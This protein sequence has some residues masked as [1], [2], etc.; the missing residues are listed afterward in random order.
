M[1]GH[2]GLYE[3]DMS[4]GAKNWRAYL[5]HHMYSR[6]II[7]DGVWRF[8]I[9]TLGAC[10]A[11]MP[12]R[13]VDFVVRRVDGTD[14]RMHPGSEKDTVPIFG[15]LTDWLQDERAAPLPPA[16]AVSRG[17]IHRD[18]VG[19]HCLASGDIISRTHIKQWLNERMETWEASTLVLFAS[20]HLH[21]CVLHLS[22]PWCACCNLAAV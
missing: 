8:E 9:R 13:R 22:P 10:Y 2:T 16:P 1:L 14:V 19:F 21:S 7:G 6:L 5:A 20:P 15:R 18:R 11:T 3:Y 17:L 4:A 12:A